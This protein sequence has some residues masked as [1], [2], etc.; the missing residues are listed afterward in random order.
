MYQLDGHS[1][2][3]IGAIRASDD[4]KKKFA[5]ESIAFNKKDKEFIDLFGADGDAAELFAEAEATMESLRPSGKK[6]VATTTTTTTTADFSEKEKG[7]ELTETAAGTAT[8][9]LEE[10]VAPKPVVVSSGGRRKKG[11]SKGLSGI[12]AAA[13]LDANEIT[14][15][16]EKEKEPSTVFSEMALEG[17]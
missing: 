9:V 8:V 14:E 5:G 12:L 6:E 7:K 2:S 16:A 3:S 15:K 10:S 1:M 11:G 13:G 4:D 17:K